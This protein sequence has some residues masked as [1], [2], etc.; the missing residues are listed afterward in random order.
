M[1]LDTNIIIAY[2]EGD[3]P[4][5]QTLSFWKE[6]GY[7]LILSTVVE[8]EVLCF[9]EWTNEERR[10]TEFFLETHFSSVAFDRTSARI[11]AG[12][13]RDTKIKFPDAAIAAT[14]ISTN[15]PL[16]TRNVRDF[17]HIPGLKI[18]AL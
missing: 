15:T 5:I 18:I 8:S 10:K 17:K 12:I 14:A 9:S 3:Q 7:P 1:T 16:V 2:L 11:A 6:R 4:V 13:R